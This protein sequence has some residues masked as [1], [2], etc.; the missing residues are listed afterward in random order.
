MGWHQLDQQPTVCGHDDNSVAILRRRQRKADR[1]TTAT[2][3]GY[4][5][6]RRTERYEPLHAL[7]SV[8]RG[9]TKNNA[10]ITF[11]HRDKQP[12]CER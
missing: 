2:R 12:R 10:I 6:F 9:K 7:T 5:V 1:Q 4:G 8:F 11:A 3:Y